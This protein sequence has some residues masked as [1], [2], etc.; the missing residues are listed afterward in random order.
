MLDTKI[1]FQGNKWLMLSMTCWMLFKK[2][3]IPLR[4]KKSLMKLFE[5]EWI[6][7]KQSGNNN[8]IASENLNREKASYRKF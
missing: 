4:N 6:N 3:E 8:K 2:E 1:N 5:E 7:R